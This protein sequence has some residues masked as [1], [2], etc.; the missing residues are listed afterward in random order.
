MGGT[1]HTRIGFD[2]AHYSEW[3]GGTLHIT[4]HNTQ[5]QGGEHRTRK[6]V[7]MFTL[8]W[9]HR[10]EFK[11]GCWVAG[12]LAGWVNS[13]YSANPGSILQAETCKILSKA[14]NPRWSRVWQYIQMFTIV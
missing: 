3:G 10:T 12:W 1:P 8:G 7:Q 14:E 13:D 11:V 9:G 4:P 5:K 2:T 6:C